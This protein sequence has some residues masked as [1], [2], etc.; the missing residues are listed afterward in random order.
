MKTVAGSSIKQTN[1]YKHL[2]LNR[3]YQILKIKILLNL[4]RGPRLL[5][6]GHITAQ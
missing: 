5:A 3:K 6:D 2:K 4:V 1:K